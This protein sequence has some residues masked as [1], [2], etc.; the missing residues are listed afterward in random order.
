[1]LNTLIVIPAR[2]NSSRFPGKPLVDIAGT[3]MIQRT[4]QQAKK[5]KVEKVIIATDDKR[6]FN[7]CQEFGANVIMTSTKHQTGTD[8][9]VEAIQKYPA[10]LIINIQGDEPLIPPK[11]INQLIDNMANYP[12]GTVAYHNDNY[13]D[14][15]D[16]NIVKVVL[17]KNSEALYFSRAPI[18]HPQK[19][20]NFTK[21]LSHWGIYAYKYEFL[22]KF[23]SWEQSHTEKL[24]SLEQLRALENNQSI[25]VIP[26]NEQSIGIDTP[27]DIQKALLFLKN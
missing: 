27:E 9:I 11:L 24:E 19:K 2:Y 22:K 3:S 14:F 21:F 18:P 25:L 17:N 26:S 5:T 7:H 8:R 16:P 20:E 1:M 15:L 23:S 10:K 4:Y 13:K 6:I 12:M